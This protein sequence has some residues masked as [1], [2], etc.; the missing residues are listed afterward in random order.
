MHINYNLKHVCPGAR[1]TVRVL[2][3]WSFR[4][5]CE[6]NT[7]AAYIDMGPSYSRPGIN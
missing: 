3:L 2:C 1:L 5:Y 7:I 4:S 6:V